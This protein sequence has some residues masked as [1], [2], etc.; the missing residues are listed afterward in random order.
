M[1][2][3]TLY[4]G[5]IIQGLEVNRELKYTLIFSVTLLPYNFLP[6]KSRNK[7]IISQTNRCDLVIRNKAWNLFLNCL[8]SNPG[9]RHKIL[10]PPLHSLKA[11]KSPTVRNSL[12]PFSK[13]VN[14]IVD[15]TWYIQCQL[16]TKICQSIKLRIFCVVC[17]L[18]YDIP[19]LDIGAE[20]PYISRDGVL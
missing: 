9:H 11:Q 7:L 5:W 15:F 12:P 6:G 19:S 20:K 14:I 17:L 16:M 10:K 13:Y 4:C 1:R 3:F 18:F 2:L 8:E